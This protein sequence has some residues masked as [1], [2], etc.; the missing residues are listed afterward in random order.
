M[1]GRALGGGSGTVLLLTERTTQMTVIKSLRRMARPAR[2]HDGEGANAEVAAAPAA[3][4]LT[5]AEKRPTKQNL[6]LDL[7]QM[8]GG[9][10]LSVIVEATGWLPHTARAF[11]TGLRKK[12]HAIGRI[13]LEGET[14]YVIVPAPAS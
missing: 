12:G 11:L 14:R 6:V 4:S 13:K 1:I 2:T 9:V 3:A 10:P 5:A 8:E 7:L